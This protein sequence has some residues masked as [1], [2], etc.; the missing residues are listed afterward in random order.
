MR[1]RPPTDTEYATTWVR[2]AASKTAAGLDAIA[3][4]N[5]CIAIVGVVAEQQT[6]VGGVGE[7]GTA[8]GA[9]SNPG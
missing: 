7:R 2:A 9:R 4:D 8:G 3:E 1:A 6:G 5:E